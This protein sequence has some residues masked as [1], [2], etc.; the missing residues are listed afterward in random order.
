MSD[1]QKR[2]KKAPIAVLTPEQLEANKAARE[3]ALAEAK[4][5]Q[6]RIELYGKSVQ[7]MS[8]RQLRSEL[9]K[10]IKREHVKEAG[11]RRPVPVAG[12]T[13]AFGSILLAVLDN[14]KTVVDKHTRFDQINPAP[15][16]T[17]NPGW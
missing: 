10:T 16:G 4:A 12:L 2:H 8:H 17:M 7:T 1:N 11:R 6:E 3:Q 15:R 9:K 13:I 5:E 14:T